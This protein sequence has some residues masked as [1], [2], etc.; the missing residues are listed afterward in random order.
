M[1]TYTTRLASS[2]RGTFNCF[3]SSS[4]FIKSTAS[5]SWKLSDFWT[6]S[7]M[8]C[9]LNSNRLATCNFQ[10]EHITY[11]KIGSKRYII[12][13]S[14]LITMHVICFPNYSNG[15]VRIS[16][17]DDG[18]HVNDRSH[19]QCFSVFISWH[20]ICKPKRFT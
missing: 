14:I 6:V 12:N 18:S 16:Y 1:R 15:K 2:R 20:T 19:R 10:V 17:D 11:N 13:S 5:F 4:C 8:I 9:W 7:Q 3:N